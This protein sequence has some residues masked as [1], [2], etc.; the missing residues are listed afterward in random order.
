MPKEAEDDSMQIFTE[1]AKIL[2]K[3]I[4]ISM[5]VFARPLRLC[6]WKSSSLY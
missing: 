1:F 3:M 4:I 2:F 5:M 6:L